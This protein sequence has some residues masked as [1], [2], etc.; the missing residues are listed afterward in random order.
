MIYYKIHWT[1]TG[2]TFITSKT[3]HSSDWFLTKSQAI[4][5]RMKELIEYSNFT[6][7]QFHSIA[8]QNLKDVDIA[9]FEYY[10]YNIQRYIKRIA[11]LKEL[12]NFI[13]PIMSDRAT[14]LE[15][16]NNQ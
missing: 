4:T 7:K 9:T 11:Q 8:N 3:R 16:Q 14:K 10:F 5:A 13:G 12:Q 2:D 1:R 6:I 15:Y